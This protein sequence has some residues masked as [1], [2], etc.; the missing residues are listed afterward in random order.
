MTS[1][2]WRSLLFVPGNRPER[3]AK[4]Y[5]CGADAL[6]LDLEDAVGKAHKDS[7]RSHIANALRLPT[8]VPVAVRINGEDTKWHPADVQCLSQ[9]PDSVFVMLPKARLSSIRR[10]WKAIQPRPLIALVEDPKGLLEAEEIA[11]EPGVV[12]LMLGGADLMSR[13][14]GEISWDGLVYARGLLVLAAAAENCLAIDMPCFGLGDSLVDEAR[15][16]TQRVAAMGYQCKAAIHPAQIPA[17]HGVLTPSSQ[18]ITRA[19]AMLQVYEDAGG[20]V[21]EFEG[22]MLDEPI[23]ISARR[24]LAIAKIATQKNRQEQTS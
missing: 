4:A 18:D 23:L 3:F 22:K 19:Q 7:A 10:L 6:C 20:D 13:L 1:I 12:A 8:D 21:V 14:G 2:L 11:T 15:T 24:T 5:A 17:I 9:T 16:E